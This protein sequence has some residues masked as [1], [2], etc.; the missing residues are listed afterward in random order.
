MIIANI[1][2]LY[3][4]ITMADISS[5]KGFQLLIFKSR[6]R[7]LLYITVSTIRI[8]FSM[9]E[10][11]FYF[12]KEKSEILLS[13]PIIIIKRNKNDKQTKNNVILSV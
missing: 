5:C 3:L 4:T 1:T 9:L 12:Y 7:R 8:F 2:I 6:I 11:P 13:S 10:L